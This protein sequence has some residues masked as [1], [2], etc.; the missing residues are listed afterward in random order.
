MA[1]MSRKW[2][3]SRH[4]RGS[5]LLTLDCLSEK[6][7]L[8]VGSRGHTLRDNVKKPA[9]APALKRIVRHP[10]TVSSHSCISF[11][12][13][14]LWQ[15]IGYSS[16]LF[17]YILS[18]KAFSFS[19]S[20]IPIPGPLFLW[21]A[22]L[23]F[24][25]LLPEF[26]HPWTPLFLPSCST[27]LISEKQTKTTEGNFITICITWVSHSVPVFSRTKPIQCPHLDLTRKKRWVSLLWVQ[28][29]SMR[30]LVWHCPTH[31][32]HPPTRSY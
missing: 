7:C 6:A 21:V 11:P 4:C 27:L 2:R 32:R 20:L 26:F 15:Q 9:W 16:V 13:S 30:A 28:E 10:V 8:D 1:V 25:F 5:G 22:H 31:P 23:I 29:E 17:L 19:I 14:S 24:P 12:C 3:F 18:H